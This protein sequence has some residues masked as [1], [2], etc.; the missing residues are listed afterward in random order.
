[1]SQE[2]FNWKSLFVNEGKD[3]SAPQAKPDISQ[4]DN[5]TKFPTQ[6]R[7]SAPLD[8]SGN[9]FIG[10][11][12]DVY[13][14]GFESLNSSEFDFFE[15]YKS[16]MV[17]GVTNQQ[18]YQMAFTM[19][20]ALKPDLSKQFLLDKAKYYIDEIEKVYAKYDA[21][22]NSKKALLSQG[23][24]TE[25]DRMSKNIKDIE[26]R[27]TQL[28]YDLQKSKEE[29]ERIDANSKEKFSEIELKLEANTIA[30]QKILTSINQVVTGVNQYL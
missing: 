6:G 13:E 12:W 21:A 9:P 19:G 7:E 1:M 26:S 14:K 3:A 22:G 8:A 4:P 23:I 27:I 10:E 16:V 29:L 17:V 25:K 15:L 28:Q 2:G 30:R 5:T 24:A 20:K 11:I 18:S